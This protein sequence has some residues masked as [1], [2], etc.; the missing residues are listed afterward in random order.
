MASA[1]PS[2]S[3]PLLMILLIAAGALIL[4]AVAFLLTHRKT[5]PAPASG[6]FDEGTT[7][8]VDTT[9]PAPREVRSSP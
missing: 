5:A 2:A 6:L 3:S 8:P 1:I 7:M 9:L 4:G